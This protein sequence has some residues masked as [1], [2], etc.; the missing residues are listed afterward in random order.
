M[1]VHIT[2]FLS[3]LCLPAVLLCAILALQNRQAG[4][5]LADAQ[6][7]LDGLRAEN[8]QLKGAAGSRENAF[9]PIIDQYHLPGGI[10]SQS[11]GNTAEAYYLL[12]EGFLLDPQSDDQFVHELLKSDYDQAFFERFYYNYENNQYTGISVRETHDAYTDSFYVRGTGAIA[13]SYLYDAVPRL[14]SLLYD[15]PAPLQGAMDAELQGTDSVSCL[16]ID[17][18]G[19]GHDER[20]VFL[21]NSETVSSKILLYNSAWNKLGTLVSL[22]NGRWV[23]LPGEIYENYLSPDDVTLFDV[24][25]DGAMEILMRVPCHEGI[26]LAITRFDGVALS[27][28][29]DIEASVLP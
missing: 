3:L 12:Y 19:N 9:A 15:T 7:A 28:A 2:Q 22:A 11:G 29:H 26:R 21:Q 23:G 25:N 16:Q 17:L 10:F 8:E 14:P 4:A 20:I 5:E 13:S 1:K 27:G 24:D 18:D 6:A